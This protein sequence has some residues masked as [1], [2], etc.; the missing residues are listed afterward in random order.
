MITLKT[1]KEMFQSKG[2]PTGWTLLDF[3]QWH[4]SDILGNALRGKLAEYIVAQAIGRTDGARLEWNAY[5]VLCHDGCKVEVKSA[6]Y[7]QS[8]KQDRLSKISFG[9]KPTMGWDA[10]T[11]TYDDS[12]TR[13]ADVYVFCVFSHKDPVSADPLCLDQW[14]FFVMSTRELDRLVPNQKTITLSS[15]MRLGPIETE[16]SGLGSAIKQAYDCKSDFYK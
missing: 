12:V 15:L 8:W 5:D 14:R 3:W 16:Y 7:L 10:E 1:G 4:G 11:N 2:M 13:N 6:A 9:I